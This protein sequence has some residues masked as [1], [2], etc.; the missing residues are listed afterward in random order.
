MKRILTA[1]A[2]ALAAY[3]ADAQAIENF[4]LTNVITGTPVSLDTYPSCAGIVIIFTTNACAYDEHYRARIAA[5]AKDYHD[6]VPI[7]LVN[8][9]IE[10][11]ESAD[12][13][14]RKS[15]QLSLAI[16]YLADK[17]QTLLRLL[18]ATK[19]P[20]AF[21]LKNNG[22]KFY[23]VYDGAI[24]DNP[25]LPSGVRHAYLKDAIDIMLTNQTIETPEVRPVGCSIR[26]KG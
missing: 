21:L 11:L 12:N 10:N 22:G 14:L 13:M 2:F 20:Q 6:K 3:N 24:D 18:G 5:L 23:K 16:P 17:D 26:K 8:S 19:T 9:S 15:Q 25:Q 4:S 1:L 7:L